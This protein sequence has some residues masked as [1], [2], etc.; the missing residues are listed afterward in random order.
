M[1]TKRKVIN[2]I[3]I[4]II[5]IS[6][7][8]LIT[9]PLYTYFEIEHLTSSFERISASSGQ[10]MFFNV[11][12][13][14][15]VVGPILMVLIACNSI[16]CAYSVYRKSDTRDSGLHAALP[17]IIFLLMFMF[18][19]FAPQRA[20]GCYV[21]YKFTEF[22]CH[23]VVFVI[24]SMMFINIILG[25]LKRSE[26]IVPKKETVSEV[27]TIEKSS[28]DELKKFKELLDMGAITQEEYDEKKKQLLT[29]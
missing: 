3:E 15:L 2:I 18:L 17:I 1:N 9:R 24:L 16:M 11:F 8:L 7:I 26:L 29:Q 21:D 14:R 4:A 25:F 20:K 13:G 6:V 28:A 5:L 12:K 19:A 27:I 23:S 22:Q 10:I